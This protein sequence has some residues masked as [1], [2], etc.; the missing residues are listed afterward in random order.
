MP[1]SER[2]VRNSHLQKKTAAN[3]VASRTIPSPVAWLILLK[4]SG[5]Q[6]LVYDE[7]VEE[8]PALLIR[9][10]TQ[11]TLNDEQWM[12]SSPRKMESPRRDSQQ[13]AS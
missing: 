2:Q 5:V 9:Q 8:A 13:A 6:N 11:H 7:A 10:Q 3:G 4:G 1:K 12:G